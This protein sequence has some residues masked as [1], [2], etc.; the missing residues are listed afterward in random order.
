MGHVFNYQVSIYED[1]QKD[2]SLSEV[3]VT[4]A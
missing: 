4:F 1:V 3:E 2:R